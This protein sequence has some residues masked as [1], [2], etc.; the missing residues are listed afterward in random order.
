MIVYRKE[1][2][3]RNIG[4]VAQNRV[5]FS[6]LKESENTSGSLISERIIFLKTA[7]DT[8]AIWHSLEH[9]YKDFLKP[10]VVLR[11]QSLLNTQEKLNVYTLAGKENIPHIIQS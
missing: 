2:N 11:I 3:Y 8:A 9:R 1:L 4:P 5:F 6:L 10:V 7:E